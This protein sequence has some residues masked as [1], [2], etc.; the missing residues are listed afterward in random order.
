[1]PI[2][3]I[4]NVSHLHWQILCL[5]KNEDRITIL[6]KDSYGDSSNFRDQTIDDLTSHFHS[7]ELE[8]I[9]IFKKHKEQDDNTSCGIFALQNML[10]T[11]KELKLNPNEFIKQS[12]KFNKFC[13]Q[14]EAKNLRKTFAD[15]YAIEVFEQEFMAFKNGV[16][17]TKIRNHHNTEIDNILTIL[18][19]QKDFLD[20]KIINENIYSV[21]HEYDEIITIE[22]GFNSPEIQ[23]AYDY[24]YRISLNKILDSDKQV[25]LSNARTFELKK[26][27][28]TFENNVIVILSK[29]IQHKQLEKMQILM[30]SDLKKDNSDLDETIPIVESVKRLNIENEAL[31]DKFFNVINTSYI[32]RE[33]A[34]RK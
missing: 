16:A 9:F 12:S 28:Y 33:N 31:L 10:I 13:T 32:K 2:F 1:M 23:N 34:L 6:C 5:I 4:Y 8:T 7:Y 14:K 19:Q 20:Y 22:I 30:V 24:H 29:K 11:A 25:E 15:I 17:R 21:D 27:D 26:E 18:K 3:F